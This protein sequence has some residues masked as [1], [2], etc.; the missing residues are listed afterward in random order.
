MRDLELR[1]AE[2]EDFPMFLSKKTPII[3]IFEEYLT[4]FMDPIYNKTEEKPCQH[5]LQS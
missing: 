1:D 5:N 4:G 2:V 3:S